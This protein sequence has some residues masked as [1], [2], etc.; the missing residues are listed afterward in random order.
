MVFHRPSDGNEVKPGGEDRSVGFALHVAGSEVYIWFD[1]ADFQ[2]GIR[3]C[4]DQRHRNRSP[5]GDGRSDEYRRGGEP[6]WYDEQQY[7]HG[8]GEHAEQRER[9]PRRGH[10]GGDG[11]I[12]KEQ[13]PPAG[14]PV[15]AGPGQPERQYGAGVI[16]VKDARKSLA[17]KT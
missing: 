10:G 14:Q 3:Q 2:P 12:H 9:H 15:Y 5:E 1:V 8:A 7:P 17:T 4:G 6:P 16:A 13:R 11:G